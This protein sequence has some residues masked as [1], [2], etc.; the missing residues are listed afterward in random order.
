LRLRKKHQSKR[1]FDVLRNAP[2]LELQDDIATQT[3]PMPIYAEGEDATFVGRIRQD[4]DNKKGFHLWIVSDN[5]LKGAAL[6]SIQIAE[7]M[8]EDNL[9]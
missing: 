9:L 1:F 3:Y 2:G 4:L 7:A 5:L 8:L 6:N